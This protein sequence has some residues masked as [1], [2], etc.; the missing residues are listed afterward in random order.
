MDEARLAA[1]RR[2]HAG[3][4]L[5]LGL[6]HGL[7]AVPVGLVF[8]SLG[9]SPSWTAAVVLLLAAILVGAGFWR[10]SLLH[11]A[12]LGLLGVLAPLLA[13]TFM[14]TWG[15]ALPMEQ[16]M[17]ACSTLTVG[18]GV[19]LGTLG[20]LRASRAHPGTFLAGLGLTALLAGSGGCLAADVGHAL[21][22]AI[23]LP[24]AAA[25]AWWLGQRLSPAS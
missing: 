1:L 2:A 23:A 3:G 4:R 25:P 7:L 14:A 9:A 11:G 6:V 18:V 16:C 8:L 15:A 19:G 21:G 13:A 12:R 24:L 22:L 5:R 17:Q 10:T 20:G